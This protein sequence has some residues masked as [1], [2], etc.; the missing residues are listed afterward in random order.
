MVYMSEMPYGPSWVDRLTA[1]IERLPAPTWLVYLL[2]ALPWALVFVGVQAWQGAYRAKGFYGWHI[3]VA[4]QPFYGVFALHYLDRV[5]DKAVHRFHSTMKAD[6]IEFDSAL[7]RLTMLP[8]SQ[9]II[10]AILGGLFAAIQVVIGGDVETTVAFVHV[11][12]T[13]ISVLFHDI[14]IVVA[15]AGY[16]VL[17]YH[18]YHQLRT[19]NWLYTSKAMIDPFRPEPLYALSEITSRTA[20]LI[21]A[22]IYGWLEVATGGS[23][24]NLPSQPIFYLT[25]ALLIS[26]GLLVFIW[27]LW[28][29]HRL[30]EDAKDVAIEGNAR[31]YKAAVEELHRTVLE[32]RLPEI[33]IWQKAL[34]GLDLERRQLDRLPTWPWSPGAFRNVLVAL[35][36]PVVVWIVQYGLQQ[37]LG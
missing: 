35:V 13:S 31:G 30:L 16:G 1:W 37:L 20:V 18:A 5:A 22:A 27:P 26:L 2:I 10:A 34:A 15:W 6:Q 7:Y 17:I 32:K 25:S 19:I 9:A 24:A 12:S 3:F 28:G 21:L 4:V 14:N 33:G 29:A 23:F 8:A 11:A 36:L